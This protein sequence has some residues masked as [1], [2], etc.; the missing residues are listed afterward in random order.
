M[1]KSPT[2][3]AH[4]NDV[5]AL[6]APASSCLDPTTRWETP[7]GVAIP[8]WRSLRCV[9][10]LHHRHEWDLSEGPRFPLPSLECVTVLSST[11]SIRIHIADPWAEQIAYTLPAARFHALGWNL[12]VIPSSQPVQGRVCLFVPLTH[13][14]AL[15]EEDLF[16]H[17]AEI[18]VQ[19]CLSQVRWSVPGGAD[20]HEVQ[21]QISGR[22][23]WCGVLPG[24]ASFAEVLQL[25]QQA[26]RRLG[27]SDI[28]RI[29]SGPRRVA[30]STRIAEACLETG[31]G[32]VNRAGR[33][34]VTIQPEVKG[35]GSKDAKY[36]S[37][38]TALAQ[39]L[40]DR[41]LSLADSSEI[42]DRLMPQAGLSRVHRLVSILHPENRWSSF[43]QL[44]KQFDV[45]I[46]PTNS[47]V[48]KA[49]LKVQEAFRRRR[50]ARLRAADF[51]LQDGHF[52]NEDGSEAPV[53][54]Q[55]FPGCCGVFLCDAQALQTIQTFRGH[56]DDELGLVVLGSKCPHDESCQGRHTVPAL[57]SA[58][59]PVLISVCLHLLSSKKLTVKCR[60]AATVAVS[61][62][63]C[64]AF[65]IHADE[66]EEHAW[67]L[68]RAN[69]VRQVVKVL[70][71]TGPA[72]LSVHHGAAVSVW[73]S[74][75]QLPRRQTQFNSM[76]R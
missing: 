9:V 63:A 28:A 25:W 24:H 7:S 30:E 49:A 37:A 70:Q 31:R 12:H 22:S 11:A 41:G 64:V 48:E 50:Q 2:F 69:P 52:F 67:A 53:L 33:L 62:A 16:S 38:Q 4:L 1:R 43:L 26:R 15:S 47:R 29:Y 34:L 45:P 57:N 6:E 54:A 8:S 71:A 36:T 74:R 55:I 10:V 23:I 51:R 58:G 35:G 60:H 5:L 17:L 18:L 21:V 65:T 75:W 44:A 66:W 73:D 42:V 56:V 27:C 20:L 39:L 13:R 46:P 19:G 61:A 72:S 14:L 68:F 3:I 40:L 32:W 76:L 59:E